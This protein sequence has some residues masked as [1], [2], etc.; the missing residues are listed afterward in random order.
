MGGKNREKEMGGWRNDRNRHRENG[1]IKWE[2]NIGR[3]K[4]NG[5]KWETKN[6]G[7][8][9]GT[10]KW[11]DRMRSKNWEIEMGGGIKDGNRH[12]KRGR[13]K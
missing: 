7:M 10:K 5:M 3:Q 6:D 11:V 1:S 13:R 12:G 2:A 9:W 8:K 4:N